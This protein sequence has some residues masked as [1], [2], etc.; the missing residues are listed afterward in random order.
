MPSSEWILA[1]RLLSL[2]T[3]LEEELARRTSGPASHP[4][5]RS[6]NYHKGLARIS[7]GENV[8]A[9]QLQSHRL[10]EGQLCVNAAL[11]WA[12][13]ETVGRVV[14]Y[15]RGAGYD[16]RAAMAQVAQAWLAGSAE[17]AVVSTPPAAPVVPPALAVAS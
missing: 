14:L 7:F 8:G 11:I 2:L 10:P 4:G 3:L 15:P 5:Q 13:Q 16:W 1:P 17:R 6:V 9:V 12:H